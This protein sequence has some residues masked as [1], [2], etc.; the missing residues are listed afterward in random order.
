VVVQACNPTNNGGVFL[1]LHIMSHLVVIPKRSQKLKA[2]LSL[3]HLTLETFLATHQ[4]GR[5]WATYENFRHKVRQCGCERN[6]S[7]HIIKRKCLHAVSNLEMYRGSPL[8][9]Q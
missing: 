6:S 7:G 3:S 9:L 2:T 1:F 5:N 4:W 8:S